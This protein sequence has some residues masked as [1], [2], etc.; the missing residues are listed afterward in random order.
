MTARPIAFVREGDVPYQAIT[1]ILAAGETRAIPGTLRYLLLTAATDGTKLLVS[2]NGSSFYNLPTGEQLQD[3][4]ADGFWIQ[5]T[6]VAP[7]TVTL[8]TG[9]AS[10]N[11]QHVVI[12]SSSPLTV[13]L[14]GTSP[15]SSVDLGVKADTV[16]TTDTGTFSLIALFKRLLAKFDVLTKSVYSVNALATTNAA[17]VKASAGR[18]HSIQAF[19]AAA[20]TK[21]VRLYDKASGAD[22]RHRHRD[23]R[24]RDPGHVV[25]RDR[26]PRRRHLRER[27]RH[28]DHRRRGRNRRH[29]GRRRR[30]AA[31]HQLRLRTP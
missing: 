16:A 31:D 5:N 13:T 22:R 8:T 28:R 15:V 18:V 9:M 6:D 29:R 25:E 12:D 30:R 23:A 2:F 7:N 21:Y 3:F 1:I 14:S 11:A 26:V 10:L 19:N 20:A 27:H 4:E 17:V 24:H